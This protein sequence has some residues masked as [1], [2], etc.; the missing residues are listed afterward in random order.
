MRKV[1]D[2]TGQRFGKLVVLR[3]SEDY[4]GTDGK[5]RFNWVCK[6]DC[7]NTIITRGYSLKSGHTQSCGCLKRDSIQDLIG[8][9]IGRLV[10][11]G[12]NG[13]AKDGRILLKCKCDCG[14]ETNVRVH[15]LRT[16]NTRSCGCIAKEKTSVRN[17]K[18]GLSDK[19]VYT[20]WRGIL[21]R[22]ENK[23][24]PCYPN[25]GG[26]GIS[27]CKEWHRFENFAKWA[28]SNGFSEEKGRK[29]QSI[30]RKDVNGN[31][32]PSNCCFATMKEQSNNK[33]NNRN[34]YCRGEV[35]TLSEWSDIT[36]VNR[37]TI[38]Y[39]LDKGLSAEE[40]LEMR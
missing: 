2:L 30:E 28:Y 11:L 3:M 23:N 38:A 14:N 20:L 13:R 5:K 15:E 24:D 32:K 26:R 27:M 10:V 31:Y 19:R 22:C 36:G 6:C 29:E 1:I 9:R 18:H 16:G 34:I 35:H 40:A 17:T 37:A 25:Y 4:I 7:G 12:Q 33:R 21:S 8:K 39:R